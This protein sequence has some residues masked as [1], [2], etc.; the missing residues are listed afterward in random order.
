M[1]ETVLTIIFWSLAGGVVAWNVFV[2]RARKKTVQIAESGAAP[3]TRSVPTSALRDDGRLAAESAARTAAERELVELRAERDAL[4]RERDEAVARVGDDS[5]DELQER[6]VRLESELRNSRAE[7]DAARRRARELEEAET[8]LRAELST[9]RRDVAQMRDERDR[10]RQDSRRQLIEAR[11][12][13]ESGSRSAAEQ[14]LRSSEERKQLQRRV[15]EQE[16]QI[17]RL[18]GGISAASSG[19]VESAASTG[20]AAPSGSTASTGS[21]ASTGPSASAG[22]PP[23]SGALAS[24]GASGPSP[25]VGLARGISRPEFEAAMGVARGAADSDDLQQI[26]GVGPAMERKL[27]NLGVTRFRDIQAW[28]DAVIDRIARDVGASADRIRRDNWMDQARRL[29]DA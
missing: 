14:I 20:S 9:L 12:E 7:R 13:W 5:R 10:A 2:W 16:S 18:R 15:A 3:S 29:D 25:R 22:L 11:A 21:P 28:D 24:S 27:R 19:P 4:R 23:S 8:S 6:M 26:H 1:P 17:D